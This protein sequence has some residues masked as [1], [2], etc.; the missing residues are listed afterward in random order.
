MRYTI[1]DQKGLYYLTLT[2]E[3]W[4]DV[5]SRVEY[6]DIIIDSLKYCQ[7]NKGLVVYAFVIMTNH[8]HLIARAEGEQ[9]LSE[10]LRDFKKHTSKT[11]L[12]QIQTPKESRREWMLYLFKY[13]AKKGQRNREHKFWNHD[14]HPIVLW[15]PRVINQ[16]LAYIH[17]NPVRAKI[18]K[19]PQHYI[20][21]SA[22]NYVDGTGVLNVEIIPPLSEIGFVMT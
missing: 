12:K 5:F 11:I 6:R 8:I 3:G 13:F 9:T 20:Y 10:V 14:N 16:K 2:V 19:E 22:S 18:V 7:E 4:V 15:S 17:L 1:H 21:S